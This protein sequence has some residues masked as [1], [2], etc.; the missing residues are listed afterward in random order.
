[1]SF[2]DRYLLGGEKNV[3]P[4]SGSCYFLK[5]LFRGAIPCFFLCGSSAPGIIEADMTASTLGRARICSRKSVFRVNHLSEHDAV[6]KGDSE[7]DH[8]FDFTNIVS[9]QTWN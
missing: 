2:Y 6:G 1:M 9:R 7:G 3:K 5:R 8:P 4:Q